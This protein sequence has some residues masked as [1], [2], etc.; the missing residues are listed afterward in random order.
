MRKLIYGLGIA[1]FL[2]MMTFTV[3]TSIS[4]P[5]YG[6]SE[7]VLAMGGGSGSSDTGKDWYDSY[8]K[9]YWECWTA[10]TQYCRIGSRPNYPYFCE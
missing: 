7:I 6:M 10:S 3:A 1:G 8:N 5:F 4:N 2:A 9:C